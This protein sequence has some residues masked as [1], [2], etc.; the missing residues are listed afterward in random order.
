[1]IYNKLPC[2]SPPFKYLQITFTWSP[3]DPT[4]WSYQVDS[5][6]RAGYSAHLH[7]SFSSTYPWRIPGDK[8]RELRQNRGG[9]ERSCFVFPENDGT[10]IV[11]VLKS[12]TISIIQFQQTSRKFWIMALTNMYLPN[13]KRY[14]NLFESEWCPVSASWLWC[15]EEYY[16][17]DISFWMV[18]QML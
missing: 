5:K 12:E 8:L 14:W 11:K 18:T 1:M 16:Q 15:L 3:N 7:W 13:S 10:M 2:S 9:K 6:T 4:I 17:P